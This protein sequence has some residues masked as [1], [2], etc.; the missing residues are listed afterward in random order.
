MK[1]EKHTPAPLK[2]GTTEG[3]SLTVYDA[4]NS[5]WVEVS[6][7]E[8]RMAAYVHQQMLMGVFVTA[9]AIKKVFDERLY[10][11]LGCQ[12]REEYIATMLPMNR[13]QAYK[14]HAIATKFESATKLLTD[15]ELKPID[16]SNGSVI[17][18]STALD[19]TANNLGFEKLYELSSLEDDEFA[20]LIKTGKIKGENGE[21]DIQDILDST[22]KEAKKQ[23]A[24]FKKKYSDKI[25]QL[26]EE[27]KLLKE[28]KKQLVKERD[29]SKEQV[30]DLKTDLHIYGP[31]ATKLKD[32]AA[33]LAVAGKLLNEAHLAIVKAGV[34]AS[35]PLTLRQDLG[36]M[37]KKIDEV[38]SILEE[39]YSEI[40]AE[41]E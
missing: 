38:R 23:I 24:D 11:A 41:V 16:L 35:D 8:Q 32:K 1:N 5:Q 9:S 14:Y 25:N 36:N 37:I 34:M 13:R 31:N 4:E 26:D 20:E 22:V 40:L 29:S 21:I 2:R 28:E 30:E 6:H 12:S 15:G 19:E 18:Q 27:N 7:E 17:V 39:H 33:H 10:L 3:A